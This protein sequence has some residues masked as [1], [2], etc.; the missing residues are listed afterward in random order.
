MLKHCITNTIQMY[1]NKLRI[2]IFSDIFICNYNLNK[3]T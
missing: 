3:L 2:N 1:D